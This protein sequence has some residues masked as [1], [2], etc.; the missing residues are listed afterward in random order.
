MFAVLLTGPPGSGKTFTLTAL[1]DALAEDGIPHAGVDVDEVAWAFPFP[2]LSQR[3]EHLRAWRE[4][5]ARAGASLFVVAEVIESPD[6][7]A[8]VLTVLDVDDHLL[9][10]L[11]ASPASSRARIIAREP[12]GWF[13]TEFLLAETE[14]LHATMPSIAGVHLVLDTERLSVPQIADSIRA[15]RPEALTWHP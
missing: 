15:A 12:D 5:H 11:H 8:E 14:R 6:H 13:G 9:V 7:L 1:L 10:R 4:S 2:D 3:C